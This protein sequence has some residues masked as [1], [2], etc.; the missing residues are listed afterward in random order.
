MPQ[1]K[2][3]TGHPYPIVLERF[4]SQLKS[5]KGLGSRGRTY[6]VPRLACK[7]LNE[8]EGS[9]GLRRLKEKFGASD[10]DVVD[11][12]TY[13]SCRIW[14]E[15]KGRNGRGLLPVERHRREVNR[16]VEKLI[17][18]IEDK[19]LGDPNLHRGYLELAPVEYSREG[20]LRFLREIK[21]LYS[22]DNSI[23]LRPPVFISAKSSPKIDSRLQIEFSVYFQNRFKER[24]PTFI[25]EIFSCPSARKQLQLNS[26]TTPTAVQKAIQRAARRRI[27]GV[28][29]KERYTAKELPAPSFT[30]R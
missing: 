14:E 10:S 6:L 8:L 11:L 17:E 28:M 26:I 22:R 5:I 12:M 15:A 13:V 2:S 7:L 23:M 20:Q 24:M 19:D 1:S 9:A 16:H 27:R 3:H 21:A 30:R 29:A 25:A 18:L 4:R